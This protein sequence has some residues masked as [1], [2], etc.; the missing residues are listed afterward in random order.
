MHE[1][2]GFIVPVQMLIQFDAVRISTVI[3][4]SNLMFARLLGSE[5]IVVFLVF[6]RMRMCTLAVFYVELKIMVRLMCVHRGYA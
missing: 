3:L 1:W 6:V 4:F 2:G 5:Y